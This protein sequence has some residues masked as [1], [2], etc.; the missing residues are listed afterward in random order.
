VGVGV[1][2]GVAVGVAV[3]VAV[4]VGV[5]VGVTKQLNKISKLTMSQTFVG[6]GVTIG[7]SPRVNSSHKSGHAL[8]QGDLPNK[9]QVPPN[10]SDKHHLGVLSLNI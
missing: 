4:G 8:L 6:V 2:V 7:H 5:G 9:I 3:K 10:V 1:G